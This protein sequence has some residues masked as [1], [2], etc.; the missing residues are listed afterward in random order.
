MGL[1]RQRIHFSLSIYSLLILL[2][3]SKLTLAWRLSLDR[4]QI[5]SDPEATSSSEEEISRRLHFGNYHIVDEETG[6]KL[7]AAMAVASA[8]CTD[9]LQCAINS[10]KIPIAN[11]PCQAVPTIPLGGGSFC[12]TNLVCNNFAIT[13]VPSS[14]IHPLSLGVGI[15]NMGLTCTGYYS[16]GSAQGTLQAVVK[17]VNVNTR[18]LF[19]LNGL[20]PN[21]AE[22]VQN[23]CNVNLPSFSDIT[24]SFTGSASETWSSYF[25]KQTLSLVTSFLDP[26]I[27][28]AIDHYFCSTV[29]GTVTKN[30]TYAIQH[31]VDPLL[32]NV[33]S[34]KSSS[35]PTHIEL[36]ALSGHYFDWHKT[37]LR[38]PKYL[39]EN[40]I[41]T[42]SLM[43]CLEARWPSLARLLMM[44][45]I[46]GAVN[47]FTGNSGSISIDL[48]DTPLPLSFGP[49]GHVANVTL[50]SV[51]ILGLNSFTKF[52]VM[53]PVAAQT[54]NVTLTTDIEFSLLDV[55][56][57]ALVN[58]SLVT[59]GYSH[60]FKAH[61]RITNTTLSFDLAL[62]IDKAKIVEMYIKELTDPNCFVK[63][64]GYANLTSLI[65][66]TSIKT[67]SIDEILPDGTPAPQTLGRDMV[68]LFDNAL[69]L[70][71]NDLSA[72]V[73]NVIAGASQGPLR[74]MIDSLLTTFIKKASQQCPKV[75]VPVPTNVPGAVVP[76]AG[77]PIF[78][79]ID[80]VL[81][82]M[83]GPEGLNEALSCASNGTGKLYVEAA[84]WV[85][86]VKL[87]SF[88]NFSILNPINNDPKFPYDLVNTVSFNNLLITLQ[89]PAKMSHSRRRLQTFSGPFL[90]SMV[91]VMPDGYNIFPPNM[92]MSIN[93]TDLFVFADVMVKQNGNKIMN[94]R[95]KQLLVGGCL[96]STV[97]AV[98]LHDLKVG[99]SDSRMLITSN[100]VVKMSRDIS[101][102]M[103][104][105]MKV[106]NH[107][108]TL[109]GLNA[110]LTKSIV[111]DSVIMCA[112]NGSMPSNTVP[113]IPDL[114]TP[115][116]TIAG[117]LV[118]ILIVLVAF[119]AYCTYEWKYGPPRKAICLGSNERSK[120]NSWFAA[121]WEYLECDR[122]MILDD[123]IPFP[124][125]MLALWLVIS[126]IALF[127]ICNL[128]SNAATVLATVRVGTYTFSL[129]PLLVFGL[130]NT[131]ENLW[132]NKVWLLA[133]IIALYSGVWLYVKLFVILFSLILPPGI[134]SVKLRGRSLMFLD[135]SGK[136]MLVILFIMIMF[137]CAFWITLAVVPQLVITIRVQPNFGFYSIVLAMILSLISGH[138][139]LSMHRHMV[140]NDVQTTSP[141][142][143]ENGEVEVDGE[144][145]IEMKTSP[146]RSPMKI[147]PQNET[148]NTQAG[149]VDEE[150]FEDVSQA[151][152]DH[153]FLVSFHTLFPNINLQEIEKRFH[154][155][156]V[157][158]TNPPTS[159]STNPLHEHQHENEPHKATPTPINTKQGYPSEAKQLSALTVEEVTSLFARDPSLS[160][161]SSIIQAKGIDG[162]VLDG[163]H[164]V[165]DIQKAIEVTKVH[166][167]A[168]KAKLTEWKE[169]GIDTALF[170]APVPITHYPFAAK[171]SP[172]PQQLPTPSVDTTSN[173][174]VHLNHYEVMLLDYIKS[175]KH[176]LHVR[177]T[178]AGRI[179]LWL[180]ICITGFMVLFSTCVTTI[181]FNITG[182]VGFLMGSGASR[183]YSF[184]SIGST[185]PNASGTPND[186]W[187][188]F[189]SIMYLVFVIIMPFA[190]VISAL[191]LWYAP[192]SHTKWA[193]RIFVLAEVTHAWS[194]LDVFIFSLVVSLIGLT[195]FYS[196]VVKTNCDFINIIMTTI[197]AD[198]INH[199][200]KCID[201]NA[202]LKRKSITLFLALCSINILSFASLRAAEIALHRGG[203]LIH[204]QHPDSEN[205]TDPTLSIQTIG[206]S[207][208]NNNVTGNATVD[209]H[210]VR[211]P[212]ARVSFSNAYKP[213]KK[214]LS[215]YQHGQVKPVKLLTESPHH[216]NH[217][218]SENEWK[219][220]PRWFQRS[221]FC[222]RVLLWFNLIQV[223]QAN[224]KKAPRDYKCVKWY[225]KQA[226]NLFCGTQGSVT[227]SDNAFD[228]WEKNYNGSR[229]RVGVSPSHTHM[230]H[231]HGHHG[232]VEPQS[233]YN[234][235][236]ATASL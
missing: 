4:N 78:A 203:A 25:L 17:E 82:T 74:S 39:V 212:T 231:H 94:L 190:F 220:L 178:K 140:A 112:N 162:R 89:P 59:T 126:A 195:Q 118:S 200:D 114:A 230:P 187:I 232:L 6:N 204:A 123:R 79:N 227:S 30:L 18:I 157:S 26:I 62:A 88:K 124:L 179:A 92:I 214:R 208:G 70:I 2:W 27:V 176:L 47:A 152:V 207:T 68:N 108:S 16:W 153:T 171:S 13:N 160:S 215:V 115:A 155:L 58:S 19:H 149:G 57:W 177:S 129:P 33:M 146:M 72:L 93:F 226:V 137:M 158:T 48:H 224:G 10:L 60:Y 174:L 109:V 175:G 15:T 206:D 102:V 28:T 20:L 161:I 216:L 99:V 49:L 210:E 139:V 52:I 222:I 148:F 189:V 29:S 103:G 181:S 236:F 225:Y 40:Y 235:N 32:I 147:A 127:V 24:I 5:I 173:S 107:P 201:V 193:H 169:N 55:E 182:L 100:G 122:I 36:G 111:N 90:D 38:L 130:W 142:S 46:D 42:Q 120:Y 104:L 172:T 31:T 35:V 191:V 97:D 23:S 229:S 228:K 98:A 138:L 54:S 202:R 125:R 113:V 87:D 198:E 96:D 11:P 199:A 117:I 3:L 131:I 197:L 185:L 156:G 121:Q 86:G 63:L 217:D 186:P 73:T 218:D 50:K 106:L 66:Q 51:K 116:D 22:F 37:I 211:R 194:G 8:A 221:G 166:A 75:F 183:V 233:E 81:D 145:Q 53:Q 192:L 132:N 71:I 43:R 209:K 136:W 205:H 56:V 168:I 164:S 14:Y 7:I 119:M 67:V 213:K 101:F 170:D 110:F 196:A 219:L 234:N 21:S 223:H 83:I 167:C 144:M 105:I 61:F 9:P 77:N 184:A 91:P 154:A 41:N 150:D 95:L 151:L 44:P 80:K 141:S 133:F 64:L 12:V 76:F 165:A 128:T 143:K 159:I 69:Q 84:G 85:L 163:C 65:V 188:I 135:G 34:S 45:L 134:L 180:F 1:N